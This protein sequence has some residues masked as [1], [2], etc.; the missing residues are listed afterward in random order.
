MNLSLSGINWRK[1]RES[2]LRGQ[3]LV[4]DHRPHRIFGIQGFRAE[5][6]S[7]DGEEVS[8]WTIQ[9]FLVRVPRE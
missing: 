9:A 1:C 7:F 6:L 4:F 3:Y 2:L 8:D 5:I